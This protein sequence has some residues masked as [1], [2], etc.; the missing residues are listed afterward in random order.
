MTIYSHSRL[1]T[2]ENCPLQYKFR[3][4]QKPDIEKY[5]GI[6][7]FVGTRFHETMEKLYGELKFDKINTKEELLLYYE[8]IWQE[9]YTDDVVIVNEEKTALDYKKMGRRCICSYYDR[10]YP[11]DQSRTLG[12]ETKIEIDL[13]GTGKYIMQ[14][15][16]DRLSQNNDG[17]YEI[18]DYK[19]SGSLPT[20]NKLDSDR[21]LALYHEGLRQNFAD[22]NDVNLI[23][24]YVVF[25]KS[26]TS[27][28]SVGELSD[29]KLNTI[30][31]IKKIE[32]TKDFEPCESALCRWCDYQ[33]VCPLKKHQFSTAVLD[34]NKFLGEEGVKLVNVL[35]SLDTEKKSLKDKIA[36][37][38]KEISLVK[39]A[40]ISYAEKENLE[41]VVGS[42]K[43]VRINSSVK[44][45]TPKKG[46]SDWDKLETK[47]T[48]LHKLESLLSLDT[49]ALK[50]A[51]KEEVFTADELAVLDGLYYVKEQ[52]KV[53]L[54]KIK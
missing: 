19:T 54:S 5:Q 32:A 48:E 26:M 31:L 15:Y 10:Y 3:Y 36:Q 2:Y 23:W 51:I 45:E 47:L 30:S 9:N 12:I 14:G 35:D 50:K 11:F 42:D 18:H 21:Q 8:Q 25:D 53:F 16:I 27:V 28:R 44:V 4:I 1:S 6:E 49:N 43:Q 52:K 37:L 33:S 34:D 46:T 39:D 22:V 7:A 13:D 41:I 17:V 29:L 40:L 24:H 20:Q 38:E